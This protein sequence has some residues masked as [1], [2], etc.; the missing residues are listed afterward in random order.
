MKSTNLQR[1][2]GRVLLVLYLS[3]TIITKHQSTNG[4]LEVVLHQ[5][6]V[7]E[8]PKTS[9]H[10]VPA[11]RADR[12]TGF[13]ED[14]VFCLFSASLLRALAMRFNN[15]NHGG[16]HDI[17]DPVDLVSGFLCGG[18]SSLKLSAIVMMMMPL[19][20]MYA[21]QQCWSARRLLTLKY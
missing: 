12:A 9:L 7:L 15:Q 8:L 20:A 4:I 18:S 1:S 19:I 3:L 11:L 14:S 6:L 16:R 2:V 17:D 21:S 10:I 5:F 13:K